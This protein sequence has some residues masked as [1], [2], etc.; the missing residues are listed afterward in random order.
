MSTG[1]VIVTWL[2]AALPGAFLLLRSMVSQ[3]EKGP[4]M[5]T[6]LSELTSK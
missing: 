3:P 5:T 6:F 4:S 1:A 2:D